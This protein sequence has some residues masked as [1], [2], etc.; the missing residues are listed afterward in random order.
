MLAYDP[1][2]DDHLDKIGNFLYSFEIKDELG[3]RRKC[4]ELQI[5][6]I[7]EEYYP[8]KLCDVVDD[9]M[10]HRQYESAIL[11]AFKFLDSH[12]QALLNVDANHYYG[13]DL[14]NYAFSPNSG[15]LQLQSHPSEQAGIR[16]FF[17]GANAIFRNPS[18]HKF[19]EYDSK[20]TEVIVAMVAMMSNVASRI[21]EN[22]DSNIT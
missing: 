2:T 22:M 10:D 11:A 6:K 3:F 17:S 12:L 15:V 8:I 18:A 9:L 1:L 7:R 16:N 13:E 5:S 20:T 14:V 19:I 4:F 21:K